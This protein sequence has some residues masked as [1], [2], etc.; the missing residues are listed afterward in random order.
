MMSEERA[1]ELNGGTVAVVSGG[2]SGLGAA[3]ARMLASAGAK[4]AIFDLNREQ[5]EAVAGEIGGLFQAG[6][7]SDSASV[8]AGLEAAR[9]AHGQERVAVA[10]AGIAVASRTVGRNGAHDAALFQKAIAV[11]LIGAFNLASQAAAGMARAEPLND[12]G[13]RGVIVTTASVAAFDGQIG[14][15]AYAASKAGIAGMVLPMARDLAR[16][17]I[18]VL[19]IAPGLFKTPMLTNMPDEVQ[20]ALAQQVPFP[21]RLGDA[22]EYAALVQHLIANPMLNG[23]VIRLDGAI[24]LAPK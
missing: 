9:A 6:E 16:D 11:N 4:V 17:G 24:R 10:C 23:E 14:Q 19:A 18:R 15:I 1:M 21:V 7:V 5:G 12:D 2:A 8:A 13:E 22:S 3:T 20:A